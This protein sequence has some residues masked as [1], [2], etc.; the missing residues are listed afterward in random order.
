MKAGQEQRGALFRSIVPNQHTRVTYAELFFDLVFVFAVTQVSH[1]LLGRFT[2]LGAVQATLL[3]L[4]V[5]WVWVYTSWL[6]NWLDPEKTPVRVL[7]FLLMLGGL[8]LS[9]SIPTA[10]EARGLWF[11]IAY[12]AMQVGRTAFL[13]VSTPHSR[14]A[15]RLNALRITAW[16]A[17]SAIFWIAGGFA[18]G[19]S[20]LALWGVALCIEYVSPAVRFWIPRYGASS[21]ADWVVEGGHMAERC[22]GFIIIA[23]GE[24]I[25][26][27][28]ATFADLTWTTENVAAFVSAFVGSLAMWWIYFHKGAEAG[29]EQ[30]SRSSEPGRLARLAYTY[31]HMPIVAG[32]ILSAVADELV[33]KHPEGHS[34]LKT[35]LSAIGGPLLFLLGTILFKHTI[36]GFLQL[37][38]GVG[39]I[40][41]AV[42]AWFAGE[43]SPLW[44]SIVTTAIMMIV[45]VWES[46]SLRS[47]AAA[48]L[49]E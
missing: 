33:L 34:D 3:F 32:I 18:E 10:F 12:A 1:T 19:N 45:A 30:I 11:A 15:A 22:A 23:L 46:V 35:V 25:V 8:V 14:M 36:R 7:L 44:L 40:T 9:T 37:S 47:G 41:L 5:W 29:S 6:T 38:H 20:R 28:G 17:V 26:V 49:S 13:W 21:V 31:L 16:L 48:Q 43:L 39:I 24:S 4:A 42:V 27:T 2:P